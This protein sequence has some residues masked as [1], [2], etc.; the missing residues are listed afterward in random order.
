MKLGSLTVSTLRKSVH[1]SEYIL[2]LSFRVAYVLFQQVHRMLRLQRMKAIES[3]GLVLH[4]S[5]EFLQSVVGRFHLAMY[6]LGKSLQAFESVNTR[7]SLTLS[8]IYTYYIRFSQNI[9]D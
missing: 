8:N 9:T 4:A 5:L 2:Y 1:V 6:F 3:A 7:L